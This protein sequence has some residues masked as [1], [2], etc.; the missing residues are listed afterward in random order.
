MSRGIRICGI[1]NIR[2]V[3]IVPKLGRKDVFGILPVYTEKIFLFR[4][5][6]FD[7]FDFYKRDCSAGESNKL[8]SR[9]FCI[10]RCCI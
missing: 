1:R 6:E 2:R 5:S 4:C 8:K 10:I 7:F 9:I 3:D